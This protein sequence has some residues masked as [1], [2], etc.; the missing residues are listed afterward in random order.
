MDCEVLFGAKE[1]EKLDSEM[2]PETPL[3]QL[4][5]SGGVLGAAV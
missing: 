4:R 5:L 3:F 2:S 1:Q